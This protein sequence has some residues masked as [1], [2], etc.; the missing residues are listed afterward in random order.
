MAPADTQMARKYPITERNKLPVLTMNHQQNLFSSP[1]AAQGVNVSESFGCIQN[2]CE[3]VYLCRVVLGQYSRSDQSMMICQ[4]DSIKPGNRNGTRCMNYLISTL[5][6]YG[7]QYIKLVACPMDC[8][9]QVKQ[10]KILRLVEWY[11]RFGFVPYDYQTFGKYL[12][13]VKMV[14][15]FNQSKLVPCEK[16]KQASAYISPT[17]NGKIDDGG[18]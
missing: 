18:K 2:T 5:E 11:K 17:T 12:T 8:A 10:D 9:G 6:R 7:I 16:K 4:I 15:E 3:R 14:L 1:L 13:G